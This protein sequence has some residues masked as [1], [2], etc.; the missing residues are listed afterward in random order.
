MLV[1]LI[2]WGLGTF[3]CTLS[4]LGIGWVGAHCPLP[5]SLHLPLP[6]HCGLAVS[7][8]RKCSAT[9]GEGIQ[10]RQVVCRTNA[11]SLG[12]CEGDKPDTIQACSL[13]A[14]RGEPHRMGEGED[15]Q[16]PPL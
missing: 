16:A 12:Q 4:D 5:L 15:R 13:P 7:V 14:C 1:L 3:L 2:K 9:C 6:D 8:S 11:N 10:Q